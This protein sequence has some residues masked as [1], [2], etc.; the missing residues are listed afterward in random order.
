M[1]GDELREIRTT[2]LRLTQSEFALA[3][4]V[5]GD[6]T[7][8]KWETGERPVPPAVAKLAELLEKAMRGPNNGELK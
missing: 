4:G 1:T 8:R 7:V 5:S 2:A 6:R 3:V